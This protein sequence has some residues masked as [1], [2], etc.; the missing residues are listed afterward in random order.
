LPFVPGRKAEKVGMPFN[1]PVEP[2]KE[3]HT[4]EQMDGY[5]KS[6]NC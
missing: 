3:E 1:K 6:C 5:G 2:P 4:H